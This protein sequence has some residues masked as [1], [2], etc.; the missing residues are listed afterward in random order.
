MKSITVDGREIT[1]EMVTDEQRKPIKV[2]YMTDSRYFDK[3]IDF[4]KK[5]DLLI[6]EGMYGED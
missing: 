2:T 5:S 1:Q 6:S 3:M 4:A